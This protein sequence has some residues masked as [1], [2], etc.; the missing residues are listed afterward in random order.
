MALKVTT[1]KKPKAAK[2]STY[3]EEFIKTVTT[4]IL[5]NQGEKIIHP[6]TKK[7]IK[8]WV[9]EI[10]GQKAVIPKL[11]NALLLGPNRGFAIEGKTTAK[12][13]L[14]QLAQE[15]TAGKYDAMINKLVKSRKR[16]KK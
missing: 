14:I 11:G 5:I 9:T 16:K 1:F 15:A 7:P 2:Y 8:S 3:V 13:I 4:Q 12:S 10:Y 6:V